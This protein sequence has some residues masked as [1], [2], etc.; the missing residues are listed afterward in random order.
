MLKL[1]VSHVIITLFSKK[2]VKIFQLI[3]KFKIINN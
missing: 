3:I 2:K 1:D